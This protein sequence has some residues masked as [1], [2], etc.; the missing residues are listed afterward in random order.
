MI[1]SGV[2]QKSHTENIAD[3]NCDFLSQ[4]KIHKTFDTIKNGLSLQQVD[5]LLKLQ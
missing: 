4:K 1:N 2:T 5:K 3:T